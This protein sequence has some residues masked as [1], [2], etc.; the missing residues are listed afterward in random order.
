M[1]EA[2]IDGCK[3]RRDEFAQR[4][5]DKQHLWGWAEKAAIYARAVSI[6]LVLNPLDPFPG[7]VDE[8]IRRAEAHAETA[9]ATS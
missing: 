7:L 1:N 9:R 5:R 2:G 4:L 8:A 3:A 6:G